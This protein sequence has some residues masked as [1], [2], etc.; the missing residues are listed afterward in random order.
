MNKAIAYNKKALQQYMFLYPVSGVRE[1]LVALI[2]GADVFIVVLTL[3]PP[4]QLLYAVLLLSPIAFLNI[5]AIWIAIHPRKRSVQYILF[6]GVFGVVFSFGLMTLTQK[7]AYGMIGL[8]TPLYFIVSFSLYG[9]ALYGYTKRHIQ[10]LKEPIKNQ[11]MAGKFGGSL[12]AAVG[13]G[14]LVANVSVGYATQ[15]MVAVVLMSVFTVLSFVTFHFIME[16]H[17]YYIIKKYS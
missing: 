10:K 4:F 5:W 6:R 12:A 1:N 13:L 8:Q 2:V 14:Y 11:E 9:L 7:M 17:R 3:A 15:Q 16:L